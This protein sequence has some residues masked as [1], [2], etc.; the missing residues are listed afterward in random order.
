MYTVLERKRDTL[1]AD[2]ERLEEL[3]NSLDA[4][5]NSDIKRTVVE[6]SQSLGEIFSVLLPGTGA[7]LQQVTD[8]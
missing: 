3:I 1:R 6:V 5:R 7:R 8:P 2:K 4:Q